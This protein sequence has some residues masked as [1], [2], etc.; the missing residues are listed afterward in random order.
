MSARFNKGDKVE[1]L[2][3]TW[4]VSLVTRV[5]E[6]RPTETDELSPVYSLY[7]AADNTEHAHAISESVLSGR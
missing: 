4:V 7:R 5:F 6:S 2:G 3:N 1:Y